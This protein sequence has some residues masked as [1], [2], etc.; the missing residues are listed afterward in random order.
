MFQNAALKLRGEWDDR[1][2]EQGALWRVF[3]ARRRRFSLSMQR[4][5]AF[6]PVN[7]KG[8]YQTLVKGV[9]FTT[10]SIRRLVPPVVSSGNASIAKNFASAISRLGLNAPTVNFRSTKQAT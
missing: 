6:W 9:P 10:S 5:L 7:V 2:R 4:A 3:Q 8:F 1:T